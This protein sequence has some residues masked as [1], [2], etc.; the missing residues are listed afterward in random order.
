[1]DDRGWKY[2]KGKPKEEAAIARVELFLRKVPC[3]NVERVD[4]IQN[5]NQ[6]DLVVSGRHFLEVKGQPIR[7]FR[8]G[9]SNNYVELFEVPKETKSYFASFPELCSFLGFSDSDLAAT[10]VT[11][12]LRKVRQPS[13]ALGK[14][15]GISISVKSFPTASAV[16][17]ANND[18]VESPF[19]L[20]GFI[21][22][23][24]NP[25]VLL[26]DSIAAVRH[27]NLT[28]GRGNSNSVT[29]AVQVPYSD[30]IWYEDSEGLWHW[31]GKGDG[32]QA[33]I[34]LS[35]HFDE[36]ENNAL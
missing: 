29:Y 31:N 6:G 11:P 30:L 15:E 26:E 19:G 4:G 33:V 5:Y 23:Y 22:V 14:P 18:P 9:Y 12:F 21:S 10:P 35:T 25:V 13:H 16:I 36:G 7:P 3:V 32:K 2:G 27:G 20:V 24:T 1:M 17:Y 28:K 8:G 34:N